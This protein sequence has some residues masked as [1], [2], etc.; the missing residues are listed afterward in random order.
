VEQTVSNHFAPLFQ[1]KPS[2]SRPSAAPE[3]TSPPPGYIALNRK[4]DYL[5]SKN[6]VSGQESG[7]GNIVL[8]RAQFDVSRDEDRRQEN[9]ADLQSRVAAS[10]SGGSYPVT[11]SN[12][13]YNYLSRL[14]AENKLAASSF[15]HGSGAFPLLQSSAMARDVPQMSSTPVSLTAPKKF[16]TGNSSTDGFLHIRPGCVAVETKYFI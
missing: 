9:A 7:P 5:L 2:N 4:A 6:P 15:V 1:S 8:R 13:V 10:E 14:I 3:A 16:A 11:T 12:P